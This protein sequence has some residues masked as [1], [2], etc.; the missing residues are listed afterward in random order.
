MSWPR[1]IAERR[2][3]FL[4]W[5]GKVVMVELSEYLVSYLSK[6][7][8]LQGHMASWEVEKMHKDLGWI[9]NQPVRCAVQ[10]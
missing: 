8:G 2:G 1:Y 7:F 10:S 6:R 4:S 5:D 9:M 3:K